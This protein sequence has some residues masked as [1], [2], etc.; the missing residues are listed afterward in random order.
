MSDLKPCP[1][2]GEGVV[3]IRNDY[4]EHLKWVECSSCGSSSDTHRDSVEVVNKWNTRPNTW[5][6]CSDRLPE[7]G[8]YSVLGFWQ[9]GGWDM[10]HVE[11]Y[12]G[13]ITDGFN[14]KGEQLY[15]KWYQSQC[16]TH[17]MPIN[18][19]QDKE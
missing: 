12:F 11:D 18:P 8:D 15:T 2:C 4:M 19:P 13:D 9:H 6:S 17:W 1:F 5:I 7:L 16:I 14:N 10:I 3:F